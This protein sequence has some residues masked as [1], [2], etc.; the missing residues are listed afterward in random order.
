MHWPASSPSAI[1]QLLLLFILVEIAGGC[2]SDGD[3]DASDNT[4][5]S[6]P[7]DIV[8]FSADPD[9]LISGSGDSVRLRWEVTGADRLTI[10]PEVGAVA[11]A[12]GAAS[13]E[14]ATTTAYTLLAENGVGSDTARVTIMVTADPLDTAGNQAFGDIPAGL[15][16]RLAVGLTEDPGQAWM[17]DSGVA[18]DMRYHYFTKGWRDNWGWDPTNTGIW[19]LGW[20]E[21]CDAHG[22]IPVIQYYCVNDEPGG[23]EDQF[24]NKT[25]NADTMASYFDDFKVLLQRAKEFDKPVLVLLEGDGYAYMERQSGEDP[26]AYAAVADTGMPELSDLPDTAAGWGLAFLQLRRAVAAENVILGMHISAWASGK[27]ISSFQSDAPLQPEVD[28]VYAFLSQLGLASNQTGSTYDLLVGDP[29][30]RDAGYYT[31][32]HSQDHWWDPADD[33]PIDT[34][35]FNRYAEWLRLWNQKAKK[36]WILWQI[37]LGNS[38][39]LNVTNSGGPRE[40]YQDNRPEYFFA[41]GT[42]HLRKFADA[43]TI[44]LLFGPGAGGQA[45]HTNDI[46][47]DGQ[48]FMQSRAGAFLNA[49]GLPIAQQGR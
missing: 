2:G 17:R 43:G 19:G 13:V 38:N 29:L 40:G 14:P 46:Y 22:F 26:D 44:A 16:P 28:K 3:Q 33:A 41:D 23:G 10:E 32:A 1:V 27:D 5:A 25:R 7:P 34:K 12:N 20:M 24:Y 15:P 6:Q 9:T 4:S 36:R 39:H 8:L 21:E 48:L 47:T 42:A 35:S 30:D 45:Y 49:G 18:W 37:P 11:D 31:V